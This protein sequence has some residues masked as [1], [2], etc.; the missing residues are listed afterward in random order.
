LSI[1]H[2][3]SDTN[4]YITHDIQETVQLNGGSGL[5]KVGPNGGA[6]AAMLI[7]STWNPGYHTIEAEDVSTRYTASTTLQI[8]GAG[9]TRPSHLLIDASSLDLGADLQG[10]NTI[11]SLTLHNS[12]GGSISWSASSDQ[13]WLLLSPP[14][15]MFS[16][17]QTIAVAAERANLKRGD[18]KGTITFSSNV[19]STE[20]VQVQ[21]TVRPLPPN[22]GAV[23]E[24]NPP[25]LSFTALD[26]ESNPVPQALM[27]GNP[28][29][30]GLNWSLTG[31]NPMSLA[32][33]SLLLSELN[34]GSG[35][36]STDQTSGVV[37]PHS[38]SILR[39]LVNSQNLLPGV[40]TSVLSFTSSH[41]INSPQTVSVSLTIE[42]RCGLTL[43]AGIMSFT[44]VS[45]QS[46]PSNQSM[47]LGA[48]SSCTG[49]IAGVINW[50]AVSGAN[51]LAVTPASGQLKGSA[52]TVTAVGV[53]ASILKPG[54]YYGDISFTAAQSTQTVVVQLIVQAPP[55]LSA[56][57]IG[58]T[59]LSLNF[60][61]TQGMPNPP[62]LAVTITNTGRSPLYWHTT[63][64]QLSSLW[65]GAGPTGGNI[66]PGQTGQVTVNVYTAD[67]TP[68]TYVGQIV[69][70]GTDGSSAPASGSPQTI[71]VNLLVLPPCVLQQPTLSAITFSAAQG[72][73]DPIPQTDSITASGNCGWPMNW[74]ATVT[75]SSSW[76]HLSSSSGS[77]PG[78][79]QAVPIT[80]SASIAGL[81]PG[82]YTAKVTVVATNA[83]M[84][85]QSHSQTFTVTLNVLSLCQLRVGPSNLFFSVPQG[86]PS[87]PMQSFSLSE[88]G[89]CANPVS[90]SVSGDARSSSWLVLGPPTSGT[91]IASITVGVK[92]PQSLLPGKYTGT[93][94]VTATDNNGTAVLVSPQSVTVKLT[95]TGYTLSGTVVACSDSTCTSSQPLPGATLSLLNTSTNRTVTITADSS[96]NYSFGNL[97]LGGPYTLTVNSSI[98]SLN[99]FGTASFS[100]SGDQPNF[101]VSAYPK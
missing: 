75:K 84:P 55:P 44:A 28:G 11:Q 9:P 31:N 78:S 74:Q 24:V 93:I 87:P 67:L 29:S 50:K 99:Y 80:V 49:V 91:G 94:T 81:L 43:N 90:W 14:Q 38:S 12:G 30:Q 82:T 85:A 20:Q 98:G 17:S 86:Q 27:I 25:V 92:P 19:G 36:L 59:P 97:P 8:I 76:L 54:T 69:L 45:G 41:G 35:W 47:G 88:Y 51:W 22:V 1:H 61:T 42:P 48:T 65:L 52:S 77:L 2:F 56:P 53:N 13:P 6:S 39:V 21:M 32:G 7:D 58:A 5:I 70:V 18:Y 96:G 71:T 33:Q 100:L 72:A 23:L 16:L 4:V 46:N 63:V 68:N 15:G 66:A 34:S 26:G 64:N 89:T 60:N 57:I 101:S 79:G 73:T 10:A 40:Y 37:V 3:S 83:T 62:G 95:V